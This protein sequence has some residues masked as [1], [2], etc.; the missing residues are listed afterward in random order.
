MPRS[1]GMKKRKSSLEALEHIIKKAMDGLGPKK[2]LTQEEIASVWQEA[3]GARAGK[4]TKPVS[5]KKTSL[6]INV[7]DSGWMYEL[8]IK[9]KE[10]LKKLEGK[11][12]GKKLKEIRFRIGEII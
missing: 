6:I 9:K 5:F 2:R 4:H 11:L 12:K 3:V 10:I 8:T 7:D 1:D